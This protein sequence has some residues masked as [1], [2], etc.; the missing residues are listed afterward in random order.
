MTALHMTTLTVAFAY[1]AAGLIDKTPIPW[2]ICSILIE[3]LVSRPYT[4]ER[5]LKVDVLLSVSEFVE[6]CGHAWN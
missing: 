6:R 5:S 3:S 4:R 2:T 1:Q